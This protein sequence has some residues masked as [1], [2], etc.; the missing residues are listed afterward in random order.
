MQ[1]VM[2][3]ITQRS[4]ANG[5]SNFPFSMALRCVG[6]AWSRTGCGTPKTF[7]LKGKSVGDVAECIIGANC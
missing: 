4:V 7:R 2:C 6:R 5:L 3:L 1:K